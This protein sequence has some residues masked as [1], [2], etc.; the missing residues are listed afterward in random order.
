M[1]NLLL[2]LT[3]SLFV[4]GFYSCEKKPIDA[5]TLCHNGIKDTTETEIDCGG[6]CEPCPP[7]G[8]FSCKMGN[9][10]FTVNNA[11]GQ[12]ASPSIRIYA[13]DQRPLMFMFVPTGINQRLPVNYVSFAY[14]GEAWTLKDSG[15]VILTSLDTVRKIASG[16]FYFNA[17]RTT[18]SDTTS[19]RNGV[20]TNIRYNRPL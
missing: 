12:I 4:L 20:F 8:T 10:N 5:S 16:T 19:V 1:K 6:S 14:R 2:A 3:V 17:R 11:Y 9:T 18:G 7:K 13:N 15:T